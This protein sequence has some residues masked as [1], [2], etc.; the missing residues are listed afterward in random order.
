MNC[1]PF[2]NYKV[3]DNG[4]VIG[5]YGKTIK[6]TIRRDGYIQISISMNGKPFTITV[7]R[8]MGVLFLPNIKNLPEVDHKNRDKLNNS[9]FNLRW[10][11]CSDNCLNRGIRCDNTSGYKGVCYH[12][13]NKNK[14]WC[15]SMTVNKIASS[16][17]FDTKEEAIL[18]RL[19]LE[20]EY[21]ISLIRNANIS[22]TITGI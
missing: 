2:G 13:R 8:L 15:G 5:K 9:L 19:K 17:Y 4:T 16:R 18:Y 22:S 21:E 20:A 10:S 3:Y 14:K 1:K 7:H 11:T 12:I 6:Q